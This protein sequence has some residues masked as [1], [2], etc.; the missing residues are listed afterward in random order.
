MFLQGR[1]VTD[2]E[3][4]PVKSARIFLGGQSLGRTGLQGRFEVRLP[5]SQSGSQT[6]TSLRVTKPGFVPQVVPV[7]GN[8][9]DLVV[10]LARGAALTVHVFDTSGAPART[11]VRISGGSSNRGMSVSASSDERGQFRAANLQ[12]GRYS[13]SVGGGSGVA[14]RLPE[15]ELTDE[16]VI[17]LRQEIERRS[18]QMSADA[19][20]SAATVDL[21]AGREGVIYMV[22]G[23]PRSVSG[24]IDL[25]GGSEAQ[26][27]GTASVQGR[28]LQADGGAVAGATVV[29][30]DDRV[31]LAAV[32][33][34]AVSDEAGAFTI[35]RLPAGRLR[36][37]ATK[38]GFTMTESTGGPADPT[39]AILGQTQL[40]SEG[41]P[42]QDVELRMVPA[43]E[44]RGLVL[45]EFGEP[46]E[47]AMVL[48][49]RAGGAD[50]AP[51]TLSRAGAGMSD[52]RGRYRISNVPAGTYRLLT[53]GEIIAPGETY[54]FYPG[55]VSLRDAGTLEIQAGQQ[56]E[57][58]DLKLNPTLGMAVSGTVVE[59]SGQPRSGGDVELT[60]VEQNGLP[61]ER[62]NA[63][64][65]PFG[66]FEF[67]NVPPGEY[68]IS[69]RAIPVPPVPQVI[70]G[71][72]VR[73]RPGVSRESGS[74][75]VSVSTAPPDNVVIRTA[76]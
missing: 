76:P 32:V 29:A 3:G 56:I 28:V 53:T 46:V 40:L 44:I 65:S 13:V 48:L 5:A 75:R 6:P 71:Q 74:V 23:S 21:R 4:A 22:D 68:T 52:D 37:R 14:V 18:R 2:D 45:D 12:P 67:L 51:P 61:A 34:Q 31:A 60:G 49:L 20:Q 27:N 36:L 8:T 17:R 73:D 43:S 25:R 70:N 16:E 39:A 42:R 19:R 26:R 63:R 41:E 9:R 59:S 62:R 54:L 11:A 24:S 69:I 10:R 50:G 47:R 7:R 58:I 72:V 15:R 30:L 66:T 33:G 38:P 57:A 1:V 55:V 64:V 35:G